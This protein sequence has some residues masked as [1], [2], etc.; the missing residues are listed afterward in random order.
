MHERLPPGRG[1]IDLVGLVRTLR[2]AG[3]VAP[4]TVEVFN[5]ELWASHLPDVLA[6]LLGDAARALMVE[7]SERVAEANER[8]E[9]Q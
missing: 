5:D 3:S 9:I 4:L 7:A 8:N 2:E 6:Q 1:V